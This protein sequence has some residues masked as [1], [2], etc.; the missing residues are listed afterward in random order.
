[1][2]HGLRWRFYVEACAGLI[3]LAPFVVTLIVPDWIEVVFHLDPDNGAGT[4]ERLIVAA[5]LVITIAALSLAGR[6]WRKALA[7][8]RA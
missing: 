7:A 4:L 6:E 8:A 3:T 2:K 5:L 1:M